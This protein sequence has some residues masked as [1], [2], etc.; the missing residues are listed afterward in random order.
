MASTAF[1]KLARKAILSDGTTYGYIHVPATGSKPTFLLLHGAPSSSYIWHHQVELLPKAGFGI[2]VPDLLG[3]GDTDKP[4]SYEPY[5]MK[6]L[7]PQV[8][9]LVTKVL[10]T[11][12]VIGVGHDFGA[13]LL[14]HLYVHHKELFSQLVFIATGFMFLDS[15]FDPDS[16]IQMSKEILGY[17][18]SGYV[19]VFISP[20]GATLVEKNDRRVD[21]LF[22]AQDPKVWIEYFG[23]PGGFTKFLESD[24]E[25]P[26]AH[27]ISPAE[28]EMH[29]RILRAGGYTGPF[30]WYKAAVFCGPAKED[31][32]LPAEE[33]TINIPT[34]F[35][36]TLK[37]YAVITDMHIQD[38]R[39]L[40]KDLRVEKL[41]VGHWAMLE[42]KERVEALLE[43]V[44]NA[45][46]RKL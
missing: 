6:C 19:K 28:L 38:L 44:G 45:Q 1:P 25:I 10:D 43:E 2:L 21:S 7:V 17:S 39:G 32:D 9:E 24:I 26:V 4:E 40:A 8:H 34:L 35:I 37:D 42:G 46:I 23:E 41:D 14:S 20:D 18:T 29:N 31:Q 22:Y 15:P 27:W 5:Q 12:K 13:G 33:K 16:V 36:A 3:Y 11:P 30:N